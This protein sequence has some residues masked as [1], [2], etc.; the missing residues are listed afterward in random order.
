MSPRNTN[1]L[2]GLR[3]PTCDACEPFVI[4]ITA[5]LTVYDYGSGDDEMLEWHDGSA[6][7][8]CACRRHGTVRGFSDPQRQ[9]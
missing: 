2:A 1:C 6:I 5:L 3:C 7:T 9:P 8:C 4:E